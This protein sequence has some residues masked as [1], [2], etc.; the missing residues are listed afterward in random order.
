MSTVTGTQAT[1][2]LVIK[3]LPD[4]G[5][6]PEGLLLFCQSQLG[7]LD[8]KIQ[9]GM[10]QQKKMVALQNSIGNIKSLLT[11]VGLRGK[12][13]V[14]LT[15]QQKED[16]TKAFDQAIKEAK[17]M[18]DSDAAKAIESAKSQ[19]LLDDNFFVGGDETKAMND[20]LDTAVGSARSGAELQMIELQGL[21]SKRATALQ[22]TTNMLNSVNEG[23]KS[24]AGNIGR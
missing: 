3:N 9:Q 20:A 13:V 19:F 11:E 23:A 2:S 6:S 24:I 8:Q 10:T 17:S 18:G 12:E 22:L 5:L 16:I 4:A 1:H 21:M 7:D 15:P 14:K